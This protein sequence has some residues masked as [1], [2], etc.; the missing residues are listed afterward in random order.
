MS[1][2]WAA[3]LAEDI[4]DHAGLVRL[5]AAIPSD[6]RWPYRVVIDRGE[7]NA[8]LAYLT[9]RGP[10][11]VTYS[12]ERG[13]LGSDPFPHAAGS[14]I[15]RSIPTSP[16]GTGSAPG[17]QGPIGPKGETG[18]AGPAGLPGP[19][20]DPGDSA[21]TIARGHGYG[22]TETQWLTTL[23]GERGPKGEPGDAGAT[24]PAG[25][26]GA[27]GAV[28]ETGPMGPTGPKGET[29][30]QG[31]IG[32]TGPAGEVGPAGQAGSAGATGQQGPTGPEGPKGETGNTGPAG[33]AGERGPTGPAGDQGP[34]GDKGD[35]GIQGVPGETGPT[36]PA[37]AIPAGVIAMWSGTLATI[38]SG[39]ALCNGL[40]GT[41]N[42][43][44]RFVVG[45]AAGANPGATGGVATHQHAAHTGIM[46]H[47][48]AMVASN[49][50][51]TSGTNPARGSG[52]QGSITV[53]APAGAVASYAHDSLDNRPPFYAIAYIMKL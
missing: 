12:I 1:G 20:G 32:P 6:A 19:K 43:A 11:G 22:G 36:G 2:Q 21:Y 53:A 13:V 29:G 17:E 39:W 47:T 4:D 41:P 10:D 16:L 31:P 7:P 5:S 51:A 9:G 52:T 44:D 42:L 27:A 37:G 15:A 33:P 30:A 25:T 46:S 35:Q 40:N 48:H 50:A 26:P 18:D 45:A 28:G 14:S 34:K 8:E 3:T 49:T 24:G 38:P 23:V